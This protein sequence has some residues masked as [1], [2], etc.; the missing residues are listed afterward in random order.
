MKNS[1]SLKKNISNSSIQSLLINP[2]TPTSPIFQTRKLTSRSKTILHSN[3]N[4]QNQDDQ[5]GLGHGHGDDGHDHV[6]GQDEVQG[7][8]HDEDRDE[9]EDVFNQKLESFTFP[10]MANTNSVTSSHRSQTLHHHR[11]HSRIHSRN[12]SIFFPRPS[13]ETAAA[14]STVLN[15][16]HVNNDQVM[17]IPPAKLTVWSLENQAKPFH[18]TH[19]DDTPNQRKNSHL[20]SKP[21]SPSHPQPHP[22]PQTRRGHHHRHTLSHNFFPFLAEPPP[23]ATQSSFSPLPSASTFYSPSTPSSILINPT[24]PNH[25]SAVPKPVPKTHLISKDSLPSDS[26]LKSKLAYLPMWLRLPVAILSHATPLTQFKLL[27]S[28]LIVCSG[29]SIL[30]KGQAMDCL[31]L[32]ALGYLVIFDALGIFYRI[33]IEGEADGME[34]VW[35]AIGSQPNSSNVRFPFGK[36]RLNTLGQFSLA[37]YLMF[38]AVYVSKEAIEHLLISHSSLSPEMASIGHIGHTG[39][40]HSVIHLPIT[41]MSITGSMILFSALV[42]KNHVGLE[43]VLS[44]SKQNSKQIKINRFVG[45][46]L[47]FGLLIGFCSFILPSNQ[48]HKVDRLIAL[49]QVFVIGQVAWS[50]LT[51]TGKVLLQTAPSKSNCKGL[52]ELNQRIKQLQEEGDRSMTN[53]VYVEPVKVWELTAS[54]GDL[55]GNIIV[56]VREETSDQDL[57][58]LTEGIRKLLKGVGREFSVEIIRGMEE[59][60]RLNKNSG[61]SHDH[62]HQDHSHHNHSHQDHSHH[63]HSH[64]DH[65]HHDHSHHGHSH[66]DHSHDYSHHDHSHQDNSHHDRSHHGHSHHDDSHDRHPRHDQSE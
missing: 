34:R 21:Q 11:T 30:I 20:V 31:S 45:L 24:S 36:A 64:Q 41:L 17:E 63:N 40:H 54:A 32:T 51:I 4:I 46:S 27:I 62:S 60:V 57:I 47:G 49:I 35:E 7:R 25:P 19:L 8:F 5:D 29:T 50:V 58:R 15:Q 6:Q 14:F 18:Q 42:T 53:V 52:A 65:S 66:D 56:H 38:T 1:N 43:N 61:C 10:K 44:P 26:Y 37:I 22:Q 48:L 39:H 28:I 23:S 55:I 16:S 33:W 9:D 59:K 2:T 13:S 12:L 3:Q